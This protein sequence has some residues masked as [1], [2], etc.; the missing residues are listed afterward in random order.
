MQQKCTSVK[1]A[2]RQTIYYA[3]FFP[4][5][6]E[7]RKERHSIPPSTH[8]VLME[9]SLPLCC[10]LTVGGFAA[11]RIQ[12]A[13][14]LAIAFGSD[15]TKKQAGLLYINLDMPF[16]LGLTYDNASCHHMLNLDCQSLLWQGYFNVNPSSCTYHLSKETKMAAQECCTEDVANSTG[17]LVIWLNWIL[18]NF[19][20]LKTVLQHYLNFC[21]NP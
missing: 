2:L 5:T 21:H 8:S 7:W 17:R 6:T 10:I 11:V 9:E 18:Q 15:R 16:S 3:N 13:L 20:R 1:R 14:L 4:S 19:I 12:W